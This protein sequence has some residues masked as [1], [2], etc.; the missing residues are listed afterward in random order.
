MDGGGPDEA[1]QHG[2]DGGGVGDCRKAE[3]TSVTEEELEGD[4]NNSAE[5]S[6]YEK[7]RA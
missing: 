5:Y 7:E 2:N 1:E 3:K 4:D 6:E